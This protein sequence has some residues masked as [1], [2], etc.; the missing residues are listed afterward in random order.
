MITYK[1][2]YETE[3]LNKD[4]IVLDIET[5]GLDSS[6]DKLVLL[7]I[8]TY[9]ED[10]AYIIQY[11]AEDDS[12]EQRLLEIYQR[13]ID[14][15]KVINFNGDKFDIPF[16]NMRL[17]A[18]QMFPVFPESLD[19]LRVI[20]SYSKF[21]AFDSLKL[22]DLEKLIGIERN[23]PSRYKVISKLTDH[24]KKRENP[25]PI[26]VH[27]LNDLVATE[28]L[29]NI[30]DYYKNLL[31]SEASGQRIYLKTVYI[32]NDIGQI[33]LETKEPINEAYFASSNYE[34]RAY[35]H[36]IEINIQVLY[37]SFDENARGY[38]CLNTF[39]IP[40]KTEV[41]VDEKLLVIKEDRVFN[42]K[43]ILNL[44]KKI[45]ENHL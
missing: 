36:I 44:S 15:K 25:W 3:N 40:N 27:N 32:N 7:G 42:Y 23:D 29:A 31:S 30:D 17:E 24:M 9:D 5:T 43:N 13:I 26:M 35:G 2:R 34:I 14:G 28:K 19:L 4:E 1:K 22:T 41:L 16:L 37:G 12:E 33:I 8:V 39:E 18:H 45:I 38:V 20:N 11:F 10:A 6:I 21:F